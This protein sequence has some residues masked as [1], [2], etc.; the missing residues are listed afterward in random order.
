ML[1]Q[2]L[3]REKAH[4]WSHE[5]EVLVTIYWLACGASY[6]VAADIFGMPLST[7]CRIAHN[8]V[9]EMI[10]VIHRVIHFPKHEETEAGFEHLAGH[11]AFLHAA[12]AIDGYHIKIIP[13]AEPH[14]KSYINRKHFPSIVL[15]GICD[16]KG[17]FLDVYI[18]NPG[19]VHDVLVLQRSPVYKQALYPPAGHFLLGDGGYP[20]L[21]R[22]V[23]IMTPYRQPVAINVTV[24]RLTTKV[25]DALGCDEPLTPID[26]QGNE[27]VVLITGNELQKDLSS[28]KGAD[29]GPAAGPC[30]GQSWLLNNFN[31]NINVEEHFSEGNVPAS[32]SKSVFVCANHFTTDC[33]SNEG[34]YKAGLA[35]RLFLKDGSIPT[36]RGDATDEVII[37]QH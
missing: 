29:T 11:E 3:P 32:V 12:G 19:S 1:V 18:G 23:A 7:V 35:T 4:G 8:V 14:K 25:K 31:N 15:Q 28:H 10:T 34:Q 24:A 5:V 2:M 26:S 16:F 37:Y 20:C 13:P 36:V 33:F 30:N 27:I 9:E 17:A 22:P 21:Q 6:R